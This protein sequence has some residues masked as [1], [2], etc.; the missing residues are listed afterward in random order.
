[1]IVIILVSGFAIL[2][3]LQFSGSG[4]D[5]ISPFEIRS[6]DDFEEN[7]FTGSG[8]EL[9]PYTLQGKHVLTGSQN[10]P[11]IEIGNTDAYFIISHCVIEYTKFRDNV[12][13]DSGIKINHSSNGVV[14]SCVITGFSDG[15]ELLDAERCSIL[16]NNISKC[17]RGMSCYQGGIHWIKNN[18]FYYN[19]IG[20]QFGDFESRGFI[21]GNNFYANTKSLTLN[22][23]VEY[24]EVVGNSIFHNEI[25]VSIGG[26]YLRIEDNI[27]CNNTGHYGIELRMFNRSRFTN[28]TVVG[29]FGPGVNLFDSIW[30][31]FVNNTISD[32]TGGSYVIVDSTN[33]TFDDG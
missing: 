25:G 17:I 10:F 23:P 33:N 3:A 19:V 13:G 8:T 20:A 15:I 18:N 2:L 6:N 24:W 21:I 5:A 7:G 12:H 31:K 29:N 4:L 9:D 28:N 16:A 32:N 1:V 22:P 27:I 26:E 14:S 11:A 30:S